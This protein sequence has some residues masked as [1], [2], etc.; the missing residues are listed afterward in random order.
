MK[1]LRLLLALGLIPLA[2]GL[3]VPTYHDAVMTHWPARATTQAQLRAG[4]FP[5]LHPGASCGQPLAGNPNF[6]VFFPDTLLLFVLPLPVA[7]GVRFALPFV[8]GFVGARRWARAEGARAEAAETAAIAFVFSGVFVSAWRFFNSGLALALAPWVLAGLVKVFRR[9]EAADTRGSRRAVAELGL[10][11]G[12]ELLA[13][14]PVVALL[15]AVLAA[16]RVAASLT[17]RTAGR[18]AAALALATLLALL[19]AAPQIA[20][21]AQILPDSSRERKPFPFVVATGTS[22]PTARL[23]EQVVPFPWGRPDRRG[24]D[25]FHG[26]ALFDHHTPY[27]WTLHLGLPVLGLLVLFSRPA[28]RREAAMLVAAAGAALLGFGRYVP[29]AKALYP[30]LSL[31]GRIRFPVKWWYMVALALVPLVAAAA[32]RLARGE[33]AGRAR[34]FLGIAIALG[35]AVVLAHHW[36]TTGL[37]RLG[38]ALGIA[39]LVGLLARARSPSPRRVPFLATG[40]AVVLLACNLPLFLAFLDRP[41]DD[42]P[43]VTVSRLL[44]EVEVDAHPE[45]PAT[46]PEEPVRAYYRRASSELWP[47]LA[48]VSGAGYA[49]DEDPDGAYSDDDRAV[50]RLL[51][52]RPWEARATELRLAGVT[53]VV[54]DVKLP[55]PF[56]EVRILHPDGVRLYSLDGASPPLRFATRLT[57]APTLE[58]VLARHRESGFEPE[59]DSVLL[60]VEGTMGEPVR[61]QPEALAEGAAFLRARV[62][63][64]AAGVLVWSRSYFS[65]WRA[66]IDGVPVAPILADGHLVGVPVPAG[67]HEVEVSWSAAPVLLG[68]L[69]SVV[70]LLALV[71]LRR[72]SNGDSPRRR[73][74]T[75]AHSG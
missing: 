45:G 14:E 39:A 1:A 9:V 42:P 20:A 32:G 24:P 47:R 33:R 10:W 44:S 23:V 71:A 52:A 70:G 74:P 13:G 34:V 46:V 21:T 56:R 26:H 54:A 55:A 29:G 49:F 18:S 38:P 50:R 68:G 75:S 48:T 8:L 22:T 59:T 67:R 19:V 53:H 3:V 58:A 35:A 64:P 28:G 5:F 36:P 57:Y 4:E 17:R 66:R 63:T 15:V 51:E 12:L 41:P 27:L 69:L 37:G 62:E 60:G 72:V 7:F 25:G 6:G 31:D 2:A 16:V 61:V 73:R 11:G 40:V 43:R 65:A 30:L